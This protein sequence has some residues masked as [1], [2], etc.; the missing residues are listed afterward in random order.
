V[1]K[2]LESIHSQGVYHG[3]IHCDNLFISPNGDIKIGVPLPRTLDCPIWNLFWW[4]PERFNG[5]ITCSTD[6]YSIGIL[7]Y[8]LAEREYPTPILKIFRSGY[9]FCNRHHHHLHPRPHLIISTSITNSS[10]S[11]CSSVHILIIIIIISVHNIQSCTLSLIITCII[12]II[13]IIP[14]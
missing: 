12:I 8:N 7:I 2:G 1:L 4:S 14:K 11:S 13:F 6:I 10:S 5:Y 9:V 3:E